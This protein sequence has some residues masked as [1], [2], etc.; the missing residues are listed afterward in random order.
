MSFVTNNS[1]KVKIQPYRNNWEISAIGRIQSPYQEKFKTPKQATILNENNEKSLGYIEIHKDYI[2]CLQGLQDF[3]Y[4]WVITYMHFN[5]GYKKKIKP[6]PIDGNVKSFEVGLFATRAPHR[7][8]PIA[9]SACKIYNI[10]MNLG[11]ITIEGLDLLDDTPVI[12]IKPYI[13]AFDSFQN[14]KA[15]WMDEISTDMQQC[16]EKGYQNWKKDSQNNNE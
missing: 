6:K 10:D 4:I 14:A 12:D 9:I 13:P 3:D 2:E 11:V 16:R 1:P 5:K 15:G 7:I 8:N